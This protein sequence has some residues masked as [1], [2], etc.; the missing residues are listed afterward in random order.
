MKKLLLLTGLAAVTLGLNAQ[1]VPAPG[2]V[3]NVS[4]TAEP[5]EHSLKARQAMTK[6]AR[7]NMKHMPVTRA[8][9][10]EGPSDNDQI[11]ETF[12]DGTL[13]RYVKSGTAYAYNWLF[14]MIIQPSDGS[15]CDIVRTGDGKVYMNS[16]WSLYSSSGLIE[17]TEENGKI[18]FTFPQLCNIDVWE[19]GDTKVEYKDYCM[20]MEWREDPDDPS[21]GFYYPAENQTVT[22]TVDGDKLVADDPD[23]M[24][25]MCD[26]IEN[27]EGG[28]EWAWLGNGDLY[29]S[30]TTF[31]AEPV[32][33]P[34]D[35]QFETWYRF[36]DSSATP[37]E[38]GV[39]GNDMYLRGFFAE[40]ADMVVKGTIDGDKVTFPSGQYMGIYSGKTTI[41][42]IGGHTETATDEN[43]E[44]N[45]FVGED[46]YTFN[47]NAGNKILSSDGAVC[48][49]TTPDKI[50]YYVMYEK[51]VIQVPNTAPI[52]KISAPVIEMFWPKE[53]DY[54]MEI[55]FFIPAITEEKQVLDTD[56]LY[57]NMIVDG[58]PFT[59]YSDEYEGL[60]ADEL[61]N[62]PMSEDC[63]G[64]RN[65]GSEFGVYIYMEGMTSIGF[66][67]VYIDGDNTIYSDITDVE[68]ISG[69]NEINL[70]GNIISIRYYDMN[71][72]EVRNPQN[73]IYVRRVEL[74]NG[75]IVTSKVA[76]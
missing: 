57:W 24:L 41:Y 67:S 14:G 44:Y 22:F 8:T 33:A 34:D 30:L 10:V 18:T 60:S 74:P 15:I 11:I 62:V 53:E 49:S 13:T 28:Y 5:V 45:K 42:F 52:T 26:W 73:G 7:A 3:N 55:D 54:P 21:Y 64:I 65:Y 47:Y 1:S 36:T 51:P 25:G 76:L 27:D 68:E 32:T 9:L 20:A 58:E 61:V 4:K 46:S 50:L 66:R 56:K 38:V 59:F 2:T 48:F 39:N 19:D 6:H 63:S 72:M 37:V 71:G 12:P 75:R 29:N 16:V 23:I 17:G 35:V 69:V 40:Q 70:G 43:G 31:T